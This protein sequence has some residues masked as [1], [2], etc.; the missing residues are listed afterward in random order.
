MADP[1]SMVAIAASVGSAG[2]GAYGSI[3]KGQGTKAA[4]D[5]Q[6]DKLAR[7]ADFGRLQADLT[8]T[9]MRENLT[10]TLGNIDVIRAAGRIDPTSPTTAALEERQT[11]IGDRQ[12][13]AAL[14]NIRGQ[15]AEDEASAHYLRKAGEYAL[16][17]GYVGA[18]AQIAGAVGKGIS[19][20][21]G[22]GGGGGGG[23]SYDPNYNAT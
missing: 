22:G 6:A 20:M 17:Q 15:M 9:T 5:M 16:L 18:G 7:A 14:L 8:D 2:L 23:P 10:T 4:D 12:R 1:I 11:Q 3:S 13:N 19:G 21:G